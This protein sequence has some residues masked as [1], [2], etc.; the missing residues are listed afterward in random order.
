M[1]SNPDLL[2]WPRW[3]VAI[4][5]TVVFNKYYLVFMFSATDTHNFAVLAAF[6][7]GVEHRMA[8]AERV[9]RAYPCSRFSR[10]RQSRPVILSEATARER[11]REDLA[12]LPPL[13]MTTNRE[14]RIQLCR[15]EASSFNCESRVSK[16]HSIR[17]KLL[18]RNTRRWLVAF[19]A[20]R[21]G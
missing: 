12:V 17:N 13:R 4:R 21:L 6:S 20:L 5:T 8:R 1:S 10:L 7:R 9:Y 15:T 2:P 16:T 18:S 3:R 14:S 11:S 19:G